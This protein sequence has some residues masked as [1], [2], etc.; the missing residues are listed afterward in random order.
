MTIT[1]VVEEFR[2]ENEEAGMEGE[3]GIEVEACKEGGGA[4]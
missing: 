1:Q 4:I 3:A 2:R